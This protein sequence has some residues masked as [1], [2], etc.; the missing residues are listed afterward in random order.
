LP[1]TASE[2]FPAP[3]KTPQTK[4]QCGDGI[5][6][7]PED[8]SIC[9]VDCG[10]FYGMH[11]P[12]PFGGR[13]GDGTCEGPENSSLCPQDCAEPEGTSLDRSSIVNEVDQSLFYAQSEDE[14]WSKEDLAAS[15]ATD[16]SEIIQPDIGS[17]DSPLFFTVVV[18]IEPAEWYSQEEHYSR[19]ATRLRRFARMVAA[20]G[21]KM[22]IQT[23]PPF[24]E[25]D[26][27]LADQF[28]QE[29]IE[30]GNEIA[31]HF[32]ED[33]YVGKDS[34]NLPVETYVDEMTKLKESIERVSNVSI[35]N[36]SGA[37]T[38]VSIWDAA[39]QVGFHVNTNYKNRYS[40]TSA[41]GFAVVNP[42][43][44]AGA[45]NQDA[46]IAHDPDGPIIYIP[47][48]VYPIHCTRLEAVP[49]P[50]GYEAFDYVT[51][52]LRA[53]LQVAAADKVNTFYVTIH[54]GDFLAEEDD[55]QD[56]MVWDAWFTEIID[57][58]VQSGFLK[59]ATIAEMA[60]AYEA[61]EMGEY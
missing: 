48:G 38:Y 22:T 3:I 32:H 9:P 40:Q 59:W 51:R 37:N 55:E 41:P 5:C 61:W 56:F 2:E 52:A 30:S 25:T 19:D 21:G 58:L 39:S 28:H 20:H 44:P 12:V 10:D 24:L 54:P 53:S 7:G 34:D 29:M 13:C 31:L 18:H 36:W 35:S 16:F 45:E 15:T 26:E 47:S 14:C 60:E 33:V 6:D 49:R 11:T 4:G 8:E 42:W 46:R 23:Q 17:I 57:P 27:R 50:Y 43:R 1:F